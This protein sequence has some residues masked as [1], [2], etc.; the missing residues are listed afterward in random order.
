MVSRYRRTAGLCRQRWR[1]AMNAIARR[2]PQLIRYE[3]ACKALSEALAVDEVQDIRSKAD[4]MRIYGM[5]AKNKA[6]EIDAAEIRIRAERRLGELL[7]EQKS[8]PG[9]NTGAKG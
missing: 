7:N 8:G 4:A 6:L 9:L 2:E 5:Q 1:R 3:A